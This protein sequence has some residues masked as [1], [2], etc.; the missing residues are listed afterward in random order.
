[1]KFMITL[2]AAALAASASLAF[3]GSIA[4]P[5]IEEAPMAPVAPPAP[6]SDWTGFYG[7][8]QYGWAEADDGFDSYDGSGYGLHAGYLRDFDRIVLGGELDYNWLDL[9]GAVDIELFRAKAL[10]GYEFGRVLPYLTVGYA[11]MD[12]SG[13]GSDNGISYGLG[14]MFKVTD[15]I[16]LGLEYTHTQIDNFDGL[17][18]DVDT[19]MIQVR[20]SYHF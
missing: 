19:D 11:N 20:A 5:T 4:A 12:A 10:A 6:A 9:S 2:S 17:G 14:G 1:M 13:V 3:A 15:N 16:G 8:L 7:G 18:F